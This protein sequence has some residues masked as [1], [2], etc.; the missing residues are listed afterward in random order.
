MKSLFCLLLVPDIQIKITFSITATQSIWDF[1]CKFSQLVFPE[2]AQDYK[3]RWLG[4]KMGENYAISSC[5]Q[6]QILFF[7]IWLTV[8]F[9][10]SQGEYVLYRMEHNSIFMEISTNR[11]LLPF[12]LFLKVFKDVIF[13]CQILF[14]LAKETY[15]IKNWHKYS[16]FKLKVV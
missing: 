11:H 13:E 4:K 2:I 3:L 15:A 10:S 16:L 7:R 8:F 6:L 12:C 9:P 5:I 1:N 14:M